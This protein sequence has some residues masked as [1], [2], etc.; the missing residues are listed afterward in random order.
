[1]FDLNADAGEAVNVAERFPE[2]VEGLMKQLL[3]WREAVGAPVPGDLN[4]AY[5]PSYQPRSG[6]KS[7]K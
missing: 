6:R 3:A 1:L 2:V 7:K 5:D 4:P